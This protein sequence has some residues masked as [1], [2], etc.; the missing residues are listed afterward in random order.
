[1]RTRGRPNEARCAGKHSP[2]FQMP[3]AKRWHERSIPHARTTLGGLC[4]TVCAV[5]V[6]VG[7]PALMSALYLAIVV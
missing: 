2:R 1:M 4:W 3:P 5:A 6:I 7:V